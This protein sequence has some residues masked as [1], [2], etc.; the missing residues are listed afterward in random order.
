[1]RPVVIRAILGL[2][3]FGGAATVHAQMT[4]APASLSFG[5]QQLDTNSAPK[6][7]ALTN[8]GN[9]PVTVTAISTVGQTPF[10][11]TGNSCGSMPFTMASQSSCTLQITFR[12]GVEG[13]QSN[14]F[15]VYGSGGVQLV[16][17]PMTGT[18]VNGALQVSPLGS[19]SFPATA[20]GTTSAPLTA[21]LRSTGSGPMEVLSITP[22][23]APFA[24]V[25]GTC[26]TPPFSLPR[27]AVCTLIYTYSPTQAGT[28]QAQDLEFSGPPIASST[29]LRLTGDATQGSQT[30]DF[31]AQAGRTYGPGYSFPVN[32]PATAS[33][34]LA[35]V[36]ASTT[37]TVCTVTGGTVA[38]VAAGTCTLTANQPG[39]AS[40]GAAAQ[41][42]R[43]FTIARASQTLTFPTQLASSRS[44]VPGG[45]FAI[46]PVV[47]S[48]TPNSGQSIVYSS[49]STTVC[50]VS[51]T[52]VTM[53]AIGACDLAANQAGNANYNAA[54]QVT[55]RVQLVL[56]AHGFEAL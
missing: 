52:T 42:T 9:A 49:L 16:S 30:I 25:G 41:Q 24:R 32:P 46:N 34:G 13:F 40:W 45:T 39:N 15:A 8:T 23:A 22:A 20:V 26:G 6:P 5:D 4:V 38:V 33:S 43:S 56:F 12:P 55:T 1:M 27:F 10:L 31:P 48:V 51:G 21:E 19:L 7:I 53:V 28:G 17:F 3:L 47:T 11:L 50:T 14:G 36:Y 2:L 18:G 37:P 54:T 35:V 29:S 44:F